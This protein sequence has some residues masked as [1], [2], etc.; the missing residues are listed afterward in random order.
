M[1][2]EKKGKLMQTIGIII[3]IVMAGSMIATGIIFTSSWLT[4]L[5][6]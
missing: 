2:K 1:E 4:S 6:G 5:A 3:A